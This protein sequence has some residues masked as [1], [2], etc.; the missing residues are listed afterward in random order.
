MERVISAKRSVL[1]L[2]ICSLS[3]LGAVAQTPA[4]SNQLATYIAAWG[5]WKYNDPQV[6]KGDIEVDQVFVDDVTAL[7]QH[8]DTALSL[9]TFIEKSKTKGK[10]TCPIA[11]KLVH[12][13]N[14]LPASK[15][16]T[17]INLLESEQK[18]QYYYSCDKS[19]SRIVP[20]FKRELRY[21]GDIYENVEYR[22]LTVARLWNVLMYFYPY[23]DL[24]RDELNAALP[25]FIDHAINDT[26][27]DQ[28]DD[29]LFRIG[30]V[31]KD[32]HYDIISPRL[33]FL[34]EQFY[35]KLGITV[36]DSTL[37]VTFA[38]RPVADNLPVG[39]VLSSI[40][41]L[42]LKDMME[43]K[44]FLGINSIERDI[45]RVLLNDVLKGDSGSTVVFRSVE[46]EEHTVVRDMGFYPYRDTILQTIDHRSG[47]LEHNVLYVN[48]SDND[49][50]LDEA[51]KLLPSSEGVV[52]D[53]RH[54]PN[55]GLLDHISKHLIT[56]ELTLSGRIFDEECAGSMEEHPLQ[57]KA[58]GKYHGKVIVLISENSLSRSEYF[59]WILKNGAHDVTLFGRPSAGS[60]GNMVSLPMPDGSVVTFTGSAI[61]DTK[62]GSNIQQVGLQP[63]V[64]VSGML[65]I[66]AT[67][68]NADMV[69]ERA[70]ELLEPH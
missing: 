30:A 53:L 9:W 21:S 49:E 41:G 7:L 27:V 56:K 59:A 67:L 63:D 62:D 26:I 69:L 29:F 54:Y 4:S 36:I 50:L 16:A 35:P 64:T 66:D 12:W 34:P 3:A 58:K 1:L 57:V 68:F 65:L 55:W 18:Q 40:N 38:G 43:S 51:F 48:S 52:I 28:F 33:P 19:A 45:N 13:L 11:E 70:L 24:V 46:G 22:L 14:A 10:V 47:M 32:P 60:T 42:T 15:K 44:L 39:S 8:R 6:G 37:V 17:C 23:P 25:Q 2:L 61:Y 20:C 5:V 31:L